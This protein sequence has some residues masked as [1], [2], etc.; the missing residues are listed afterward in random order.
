MKDV[1]AAY[2][3]CSK[4]GFPM[5]KIDGHWECIVEYL[6]RC[7]GQQQVVDL[8][9]HDKT[10]YCVFENKHELPML[11]FCCGEPLI[12]EDLEK[13]RHNIQG[14]RLERMSI[15]EVKLQDGRKVMQFAL[16]FSK[17]G[18]LSR[19][20]FIPIAFEAAAQL[21]HPVWCPHKKVLP[22]KQN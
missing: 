14:R 21:R 5:V 2:P 17:R 15:G 1:K 18:W 3:K 12:Y 20:L 7:I 22:K 9:Q 16:E 8:V 6:D 4:D 10:I 13:A 11:C 19:R